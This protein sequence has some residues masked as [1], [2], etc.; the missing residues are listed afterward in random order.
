MFLVYCREGGASSWLSVLP[1]SNQG[2][3]LNKGEFRDSFCLRYG[4]ALQ[5]T[6]RQCN[7]G[8]TFTS[9]HAMVCHMG[10]FPTIHHNEVR[11]I[12]ASLL[13]EVCSNVATE[14]H[15]QPLSGEAFRLASANTDDGARLEI[16]ARGFW[17]SQDAYFEVRVFH[18]NAPSNSSRNHNSALYVRAAQ[19]KKSPFRFLIRG[20]YRVTFQESC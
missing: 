12:T 15:L 18:P 16:R 17:R 4:W 8:K 19:S 7:C 10:G 14:P 3:H 1:L 5:N 20:T 11:D 9:D 13:T 6:P 2:F